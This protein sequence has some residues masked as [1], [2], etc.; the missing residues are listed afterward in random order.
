[1][2]DKPTPQPDQDPV[3]KGLDGVIEGLAKVVKEGEKNNKTLG[4]KFTAGFKENY[5]KLQQQ[6]NITGNLKEGLGKDLDKFKMMLGPLEAIPGMATATALIKSTMS[7]L[8]LTSIKLFNAEQ[9]AAAFEKMKFKWEKTKQRAK[10]LGKGAGQLLKNIAKHPVKSFGLILMGAVTAF[11]VA[12]A[13]F[14]SGL[15]A[16]FSKMFNFFGFKKIGTFFNTASMKAWDKSRLMIEKFITRFKS[17][18]GLMGNFSKGSKMLQPIIQ[19]VTKALGFVGK[20]A[21]ILGKLFWPIQI[22]MTLWEGLKGGMEG[23]KK[24]EGDG[25]INQIMGGLLGFIEGVAAF[26]IGWPLDLLKSAVVWIGDKL[27]FD[28]SFLESFS[29]EDIIGSL[30]TTM[31]DYILGGIQYIKDVFANI[32][33]GAYLSG[34]VDRAMNG[35]KAVWAKIVSFPKAVGAG[36]SAAIK[37]LVPGGDSPKEAFTKA[38]N[39]SM[40]SSGARIDALQAQGEKLRAQSEKTTEAARDVEFSKFEAGTNVVSTNN[41]QNNQTTKKSVP[42]RQPPVDAYAH[43]LAVAQ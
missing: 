35:L 38:Y 20:F 18:T 15:A 40:R 12:A 13:G 27:G 33:I 32:D 22:V 21:S 31:Y 26:L 19:G 17:F 2:A 43:R 7:K 4:E 11:G 16:S 10:D 1:M 34:L 37:A 8:L 30:G 29:F 25:L 28:M 24:Y 23:F 6:S 42:S 3:T 41:V 36:S 5:Q 39:K 14:V 9:R